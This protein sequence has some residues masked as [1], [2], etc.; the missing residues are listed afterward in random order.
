MDKNT[1]WIIIFAIVVVLV[2]GIIYFASGQQY[3][4]KKIFNNAEVENNVG[5]AYRPIDDRDYNV[6]IITSGDS[7]DLD[8]KIN[9]RNNINERIFYYDYN[10]DR[11]KLGSDSDEPLIVQEQSILES[12]DMGEDY[13]E[14]MSGAMFL[15]DIGRV[16]HIVRIKNI[17][18]LD[19][20]TDFYVLDRDVEY[21]DQEFNEGRGTDFNFLGEPFTLIFDKD[22]EKIIFYH[23]TDERDGTSRI[24]TQNDGHIVLTNEPAI[25][26]YDGRNVRGAV[27]I[28]K[29]GHNE[30][31]LEIDPISV[32]IDGEGWLQDAGITLTKVKGAGTDEI[33]IRYPMR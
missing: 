15:Y 13:L 12:E 11:I 27:V 7:V 3:V 23:I 20:K 30:N 9:N 14:D 8:T 21:A 19:N 2:S 25:Y 18:T 6:R 22:E 5:P 32:S 24:R 26:V 4:G 16:S 1:T 31:N 10:R 28:T 17:D 33:K 29:L